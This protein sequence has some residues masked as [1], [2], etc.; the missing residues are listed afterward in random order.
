MNRKLTLSLNDAVIKK[1]KKYAESNQESLSHLVEN[2]FR[3]I[4]DEVKE[5][6]PEY[7]PEV[8]ELL[9][10]ISV[11]EEIDVEEVKRSYLEEKYLND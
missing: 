11:P 3:Y 4:T 8:M 5:T 2:Y 1:A 7:A 6:P 9:G 10:S